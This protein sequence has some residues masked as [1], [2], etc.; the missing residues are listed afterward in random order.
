MENL[1]TEYFFGK[2]DEKKHKEQWHTYAV[3]TRGKTTARKINLQL[4]VAYKL[5]S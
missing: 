4:G 1:K 3:D 5:R 2:V